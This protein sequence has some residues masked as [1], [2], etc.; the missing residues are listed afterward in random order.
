MKRKMGRPNLEGNPAI[1]KGA[2]LLY[3][4]GAQGEVATMLYGTTSDFASMNEKLI[5]LRIGHYSAHQLRQRLRGDIHDLVAYAYCS[6]VDIEP[7]FRE[8]ARV[9]F[10]RRF[11]PLDVD[12]NFSPAAGNKWVG[13][14]V[15]FTLKTMLLV[16]LKPIGIAIAIAL[17]GLFGFEFLAKLISH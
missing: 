5:Y 17:L 4:L 16:L 15:D 7:N 10:L 2:S 12:G 6:S 14:A 9:W 13:S 3:S 8:R 1:E 11:H